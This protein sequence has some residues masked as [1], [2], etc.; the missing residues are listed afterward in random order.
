[1]QVSTTAEKLLFATLRIETTGS[2]GY[3]GV[4]TGF[5]FGVARNQ[6]EYGFLVTN[7]H[8]IRNAKSGKILFTLAQDKKP[9]LGKTHWLHISNFNTWWHGHSDPDID[10][11]IA[12]IGD[13]IRTITNQGLSV[14]HS[15]VTED[16]IPDATKIEDFDAIED[17][18]FLGYPNDIWDD[19]NNLPVIR[20]GITATPLAVDFRGKKQFLIDASVF[21][22]S[23]GSPVFILKSGSY[24]TRAGVVLGNRLAFL[25]IVSSV[26]YRR[27]QGQ[28][29]MADAPTAMV[30]VPV[31]EEMI[32]LG[33][34]VKSSALI[35][36][37]DQYLKARGIGANVVPKHH[38]AP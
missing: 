34:V 30:P 18:V 27:A 8:V 9:V 15:F 33:V 24:N 10:I 12:P 36:T 22:G 4:G 1:M 38:G 25:G 11:A 14:F 3:P 20:Q 21:P 31:S 17:I 19:V 16:L 26:Y 7:K 23:S 2:D 5:L 29:E 35:E 32:D 6:T 37:V 13:A 28:I